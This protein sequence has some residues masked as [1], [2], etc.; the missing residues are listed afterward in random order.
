MNDKIDN[1][2]EPLGLFEVEKLH[3]TVVA[4]GEA[5][6]KALAVGVSLL[7]ASSL[8][9]FGGTT[10]M[11]RDTT[12]DVPIIGIKLDTATAA[13]A[14]L[15]LSAAAMLK[16]SL[17]RAGHEVV[18]RLLA[19]SIEQVYG[20]RIR[21]IVRIDYP[22]TFWSAIVLARQLTSESLP[23]WRAAFWLVHFGLPLAC[24]IS[25]LLLTAVLAR[26]PR[27]GGQALWI[28]VLAMVLPALAAH[29]RHFSSQLD[30][31]GEVEQREEH[32]PV[33]R[34]AAAATTQDAGDAPMADAVKSV[35]SSRTRRKAAS[36]LK[37]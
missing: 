23:A 2:V 28:P 1:A 22:S 16:F 36:R 8:L 11:I 35:P 14:T 26:E 7:A 17:L 13:A 33:E 5:A 24:L 27:T 31:L 37:A 32:G 20:R 15:V 9:A 25:P 18:S 4:C 10:P 34:P 21:S 19:E 30:E 12:I 6:E 29:F 3:Q